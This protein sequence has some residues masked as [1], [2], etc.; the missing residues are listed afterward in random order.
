MTD[1]TNFSKEKKDLDESALYAIAPKDIEGIAK[2]MDTAFTAIAPKDLEGVK[3]LMVDNISSVIDPK[4]I[5]RINQSMA[6][7][8]FSAIDPKDLEGINNLMRASAF[9]AVDREVLEDIGKLQVFDLPKQSFSDFDIQIPRVE[10]LIS[11]SY[12]RSSFEIQQDYYDKSLKLLEEIREN[13]GSLS[14]II[15]LIADSNENQ[16]II[17]QFLGQMLEIATAKDQEELNNKFE[18]VLENIK[19][20]LELGE[21]TGK[22]L[23]FAYTIFSLV[24]PHIGK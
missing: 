19:N 7:I 5:E 4:V 10:A 11:E 6:N 2:L 21:L 3:N 17:L 1:D 20:S 13:T 15:D 23:F 24:S 18:K 16:G 8:V 12:T 9:S 22:L 14:T